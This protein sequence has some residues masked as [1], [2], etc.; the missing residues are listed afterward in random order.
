MKRSV[1]NNIM[2][3]WF[4]KRETSK[5]PF[6][7]TMPGR[8]YNA[9]T[10]RHGFTGHEK[11]SDLAEGIYTT[12]YR[13]YDARVAR[14]LSVDPLF[15]KYV[16]M[17]PYNYCMLNPVMMVDPDGRKFDLSNLSS[18]QQKIFND[19]INILINLD[20]PEVS[21]VVSF[22]RD[23]QNFTILVDF[24]YNGDNAF[25]QY[26]NKLSWDPTNVLITNLD[27]TLE[28]I[29]ILSHELKHSFDFNKDYDKP[30]HEG[31]RYIEQ[32]Q[33]EESNLLHSPSMAEDSAVEFETKVYN[34]LNET[35]IQTTRTD[36]TP[37]LRKKE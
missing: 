36:Y 25:S 24:N 3:W 28:P 20:N 14:W 29:V 37:K 11:E 31:Q 13:L 5:T 34:A 27:I 8:S 7:M 22:L 35:Q 19:N 1:D 4:F 33:V 32:L 2:G 18:E 17:S 6:G 16:G 26:T 12:E 10:Y 9:H 21:S 30:T 15:E 23:N